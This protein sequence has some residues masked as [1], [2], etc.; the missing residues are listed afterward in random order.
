MRCCVAALLDPRKVLYYSVGLLCS[1]L[2]CRRMAGFH[3]C[4]FQLL[5][6]CAA[7]RV[8][9]NYTYLKLCVGEIF[10]VTYSGAKLRINKAQFM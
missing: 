7:A 10:L 5:S 8:L 3:S 6:Y 1:L 2:A 9:G 4:T